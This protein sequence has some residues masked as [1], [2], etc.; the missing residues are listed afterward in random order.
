MQCTDCSCR[1]H[2]GGACCTLRA[3]LCRSVLR[4]HS[5]GYTGLQVSGERWVRS[6]R[7]QHAASVWSSEVHFASLQCTSHSHTSTKQWRTW[8]LYYAYSSAVLHAIPIRWMKISCRDQLSFATGVFVLLSSLLSNR[9]FCRI[10]GQFRIFGNI[11]ACIFLIEYVSYTKN[12]LFVFE[13]LNICTPL[14]FSHND[15]EYL[16]CLL[17][18]HLVWLQFLQ[19]QIGSFSFF[20]FSTLEALIIAASWRFGSSRTQ[21][22]VRWSVYWVNMWPA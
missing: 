16:A 1:H 8:I 18:E 12:I 9:R 5:F 20:F 7:W 3:S 11:R 2:H 15:Y 19:N 4:T 6:T 22:G 17:T 10:F 13:I 14:L 21:D